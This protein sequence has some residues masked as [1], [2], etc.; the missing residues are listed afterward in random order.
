VLYTQSNFS[1]LFWEFKMFGFEI[2]PLWNFPPFL[3][4]LLPFN[5][6]SVVENVNNSVLVF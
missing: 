4:L 5:F 6:G 2:I 3:T 1:V